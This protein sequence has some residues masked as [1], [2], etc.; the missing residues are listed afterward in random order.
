MKRVLLAVAA[1]VVLF[2]VGRAVVRSLASDETKIRRVVENM[3]DGF[4]RTRMDP[5]LAGLA[6]D[7]EDESSGK[8]RQEV[9]EALA[10]LFFNAKDETTKAFAYRVEIDV[11][12]V[13]V[14]RTDA[15][16]PTAQCELNARFVD[17]RGGK[18]TPAW[19]IAVTASFVRGEDGWRIRR[20]KYATTSG[21]MLR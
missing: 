14:D 15:Q 11:P 12:R 17:V 21:R 13:L 4:D 20:T 16:A 2:F 7:F 1:A 3:A 8:T 10:Y 19:E 6:R 5:V 18:E 9:R